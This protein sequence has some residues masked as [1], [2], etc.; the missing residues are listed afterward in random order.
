MAYTRIN[1]PAI[2]DSPVVVPMRYLLESPPDFSF[3]GE[4]PSSLEMSKES[5]QRDADGS[6]SR[7]R[8]TLRIRW[9]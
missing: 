3:S 6:Y 2:V 1:L 9:K 4:T 8:E 5:E 7:Q